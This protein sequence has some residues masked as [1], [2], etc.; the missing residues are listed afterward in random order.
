[1]ELVSKCAA[2][3]SKLANLVRLT[4]DDAHRTDANVAY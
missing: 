1:V 3:G 2:P 4:A